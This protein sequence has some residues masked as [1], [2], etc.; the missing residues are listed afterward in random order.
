MSEVRLED[1]EM[2]ELAKEEAII[3][4]DI[5]FFYDEADKLGIVDGVLYQSPLGNAFRISREH[6]KVDISGNVIQYNVGATLF[7]GRKIGE[8]VH[9]GIS[10]KV[11][12]VI[13][14]EDGEKE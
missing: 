9:L 1:E 12:E 11:G 8:F 10:R 13:Q 14:Q 3:N 5:G 7:D 4:P 2:D 6:W